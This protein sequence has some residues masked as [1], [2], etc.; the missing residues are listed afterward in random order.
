MIGIFFVSIMLFINFCGLS[1]Y[2]T[3]NFE[4]IPFALYSVL[5]VII[6]DT[7]SKM[8]IFN[9]LINLIGNIM[10]SLFDIILIG[11]I[12]GFI[13]YFIYDVDLKKIFTISLTIGMIFE[14]LNLSSNKKEY[15]KYFP[16]VI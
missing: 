9:N 1:Y 4:V 6:I 11:Y 14:I 13:L 3:Y 8:N 5:S 16:R 7:L 12:I 2:F 10:L 15:G